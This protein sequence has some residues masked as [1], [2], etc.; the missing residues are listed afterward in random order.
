MNDTTLTIAEKA[1]QIPGVR[2]TRIGLCIDESL[3]PEAV[4]T[5]F[6]CLE[7]ITGCSNWL[8][9]DAL[10]YADRKWGNRYVESKYKDSAN[11]TGLA[12]QTLKIARFTAE[13]IPMD[14]RRRELTFTHHAEVAWNYENE[15]D[16]NR[17]L[18]RAITEGWSAVQLRRA[19]RLAKQEIHEEPN[20]EAG[21]YKP[22]E[23]ALFL[24]AWLRKQNL[25]QW[26]DEQRAA[27]R[28]DLEPIVEFY[29]K[30]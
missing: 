26:S 10:A 16:Q 30:L 29:N 19:I 22:V 14:R 6:D 4:S 24:V 5:V 25:D 23:A 21:K 27:W 13:R 17:W 11:A 15:D 9:G 28:G 7:H 1:V 2:V 3:T 12:I 8:W 18:D 20:D